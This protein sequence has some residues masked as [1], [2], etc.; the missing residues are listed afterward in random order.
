M[1]TVNICG[2]PHTIRYKHT[3]AEEDEGVVNGL[4]ELSK[5]RITLKKGMTKKFEKE[6]L[7]HEMIHGVLHHIGRYELAEDEEFVQ[8][9]AN[10]L[11]NSDFDVNVRD[12][13]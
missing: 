1:K 10:G 11:I 3:I 6:T 8:G 2:I 5:C 9:L 4:I 12:L 13:K 7:I